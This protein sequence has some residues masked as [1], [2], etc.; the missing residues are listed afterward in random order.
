M[1]LPLKLNL[2]AG[3]LAPAVSPNPSQ[4][5]A[6]QDRP[7]P[8]PALPLLDP[9]EEEVDGYSE[10]DDEAGEDAPFDLV[11][12]KAAREAGTDGK[13][14]LPTQ[15]E[16]D[17]VDFILKAGSASTHTIS[18]LH[19][20]GRNSTYRKLRWLKDNGYLTLLE[21]T[22]GPPLWQA[23]GKRE[24]YFS[25]VRHLYNSTPMSLAR[26][27]HDQIVAY[28]AAEWVGGVTDNFGFFDTPA[29]PIFQKLLTDA[30]LAKGQK[31]AVTQR[32]Y[33]QAD[34]LRRKRLGS[35]ALTREIQSGIN[36]KKEELKR[37]ARNSDVEL[38]LDAIAKTFN[39][40]KERALAASAEGFFDVSAVTGHSYLHPVG[41]NAW[42]AGVPITRLD[43]F[44]GRAKIFE[45]DAVLF[46]ERIGRVALEVER[47]PKVRAEW[48]EKLWAYYKHNERIERLSI[49]GKAGR[50]YFDAL[51]YVFTDKTNRENF[52]GMLR[53]MR[54]AKP[55][56]E[57]AKEKEVI[58]WC[59]TTGT[60]LVRD[61]MIPEKNWGSGD[62][63]SYIE[64]GGGL[65]L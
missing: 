1:A 19:Q 59:D 64:R 23:N 62:L 60:L 33:A 61:L 34:A 16:K 22:Y 21:F 38:T 45:P 25:S 4:T 24:V 15:K 52:V 47:S 18:R 44:S 49:G 2:P 20:Q 46:D 10:L 36:L 54:E 50:P 9:T 7:L 11:K 28:L 42:M 56:R 40:M 13:T 6:Q 53:E 14:R 55:T 31:K 37:A 30:P 65:A 12:P 8:S 5:P 58:N 26:L 48:W 27:E 29:A 43:S 57:N 3:G 63:I 35:V 41:H 51:V 39:E 32:D 17:Y